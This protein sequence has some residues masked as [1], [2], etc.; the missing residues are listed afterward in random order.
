MFD[1]GDIAINYRRQC[2]VALSGYTVELITSAGR[3]PWVYFNMR[4]IEAPT[5]SIN[6]YH[7]TLQVF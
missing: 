6:S 1:V 2:V 7:V 5:I 4:K 3:V